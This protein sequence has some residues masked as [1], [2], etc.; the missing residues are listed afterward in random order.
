MTRERTGKTNWGGTKC[1]MRW[2][3]CQACVIAGETTTTVNSENN[4]DRDTCHAQRNA[5]RAS[6]TIMD[7]VLT[8]SVSSALPARVDVPVAPPFP[9]PVA[10]AAPFPCPFPTML[11]LLEAP[12]LLGAVVRFALVDAADARLS[13]A[14]TPGTLS[15]YQSAFSHCC[16]R[17]S[18][19]FER[20]GTGPLGC[21]SHCHVEHVCGGCGVEGR[22]C[23][24]P[25]F[26]WEAWEK[27]IGGPSMDGSM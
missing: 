14:V 12:P 7:P 15:R 16:T 10:A 3:G 1:G 5:W 21:V 26:E 6:S 4:D 18:A 13:A 22:V 8:A 11:L 24:A 23:C 2:D 25:C 17:H 19:R 9:F 27:R 20:P